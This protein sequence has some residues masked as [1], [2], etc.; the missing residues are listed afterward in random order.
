MQDVIMCKFSGHMRFL[1]EE[2]VRLWAKPLSSSGRD[3]VHFA[4][5]VGGID[6][7]SQDSCLHLSNKHFVVVVV[8][9]VFVCF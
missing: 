3:C 1:R 9:V 6:L 4:A 5:S 7:V 8:V 2:S